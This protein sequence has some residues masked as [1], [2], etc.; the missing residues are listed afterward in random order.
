MA[1]TQCPMARPCDRTDPPARPWIA[2][3]EHFLLVMGSADVGLGEGMRVA[4]A[5][6]VV[7]LHDQLPHD[8]KG[9]LLEGVE[10]EDLEGWL[11]LH[12]IDRLGGGSQRVLPE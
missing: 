4:V 1:L 11:V 6:A 2:C 8:A 10:R 7:Q 9:V 5:A 12:Q 3:A